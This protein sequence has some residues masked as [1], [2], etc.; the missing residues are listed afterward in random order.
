[1]SPRRP[2]DRPSVTTAALGSLASAGSGAGFARTAGAGG[3]GAIQD[4][5][6]IVEIEPDPDSGPPSIPSAA[7]ATGTGPVPAEPILLGHVIARRYEV[8]NVLGEGGMGIV[9]RCRDQATGDLVAV[10]RV[11]L[12][13]GKL[14]AEYIG[15]FYKESRALAALD[16]PGIVHARDFGQL[17]DGSPFLAMDLVTG[18]SLHDLSQ[19]RLSFPIIWSI[20]DGVLSALA[21]AHARGVVHGDLKPSNV[22][23]EQR[24]DQAPVVHILDFG[25]AWLRQ[26]P[27]DERLDG[28]KSMA[29]APHAGAGTP[30]YMAP[31]QIQHETHHVQGATDLYALGCILYK[32]I[33]GRSPFSG[34]PKELLKLH[35]YH[36]PPTPD[37]VVGAPPGVDKFVMRLL[38]KRPW[39]RFEFASEGRRSWLRFVPDSID[40][41]LL[42]FPTVA[43]PE[44]DR[45]TPTRQ[46]GPRASGAASIDVVPDRAPGLL[47]IRP[48][49]LV[50]RQEIRARLRSVAG[51]MIAG[52]GPP[53]R[54]VIL[55]GPA[56]VGKTR[57]AEWLCE[58]A[59]E[60]GRM[61]P[62]AARYRPVRTALDGMLGAITQYFN[63]ERADRDTIERSLLDRWKIDKNDRKGRS[64]VAGAA[65]WLRPMAPGDE[66]VG[67]SGMRFTLDTLELRRLVIQYT[68]RRVADGRPL[69]FFFDDLHH[70]AQTTFDGLLKIHREEL[71]Q[72]ILMLATVRSEDV[73]LGTPAA[74]RLRQL[75]EAMD[76][77]VIEVNPMDREETC[78]LVRASLPL[79]EEATAE[80]ARR[81]RGFPLFAL[82]QLHSWVHAGNLEF[83]GGTYRVPGDVLAMRPKT[84]ADLWDSRVAAVPRHLRIAAYAVATL[85]TDIRRDVMVALLN[86]LK[87]PAEEAIAQLQKAEILLPRGPGRYGWP[88]ALL[89]EHLFGRLSEREDSPRMFKASAKALRLH[90]LANTRRIVRQRVINLLYAKESDAAAETFFDFLGSSWNGA[91]EP[92]PTL[93]DLELFQGRLAGRSLALENRW[94]AEVLRHV[95]RTEEAT[96]C[97]QMARERF[98]RLGDQENLAHCLRLLGHLA[99]E[100][101]DTAEGLR[102]VGY[103][104]G[105]FDRL[106]SVLGLAQ[107]EAVSAWIEYLLGNHDKARE[108]A[109]QG[110][111]HFASLDQPLGRG[112][113]LLVLSWVDHHEGATERSRRLTTEA[114]GEFERA[115]YRLGLAQ[116]DASL[117]HIEHRLM[118]YFSAEQRAKEA[119]GL[120]EGLRTPRGQAECERLLAMVGIDTDELGVAEIRADRALDIYSKMIDPWGVVEAKL[121]KCQIALARG[122]LDN[123]RSMLGE[124]QR[125]GAREPEPK[126]HALL[127]EAWLALESGDVQGASAALEAAAD[128]F[129]DRTRV[130]DHTP[131]LLGRLSRLPWPEK[132]QARID[133][134]R[135]LVNDKGRR[136]QT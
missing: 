96:Q 72:P 125:L 40:P 33:T 71:D 4:V 101:G 36:Q 110:E 73:E 103:A 113:C 62:L 54:L 94:R 24:A 88:H 118:N 124:I 38:A 127:T 78:A 7:T 32:L 104:H 30:G 112:Q 49:P 60:D 79:D 67:P 39:D 57:V 15:W 29:F 74:E 23:V 9:Y 37:V 1:M 135:A 51:Q 106:G 14:A 55:L 34:D 129:S 10:K 58:A 111:E 5:D 95:G 132:E 43:P 19:S 21:H 27:H 92:A 76:G 121:L 116:T 69:L 18:I 97:A 109:R 26:D 28:E 42:K 35:A 98:E 85:G 128:V 93:A 80:A 99:S 68:I 63:F 3:A 6:S 105:V 102:L 52:T 61:V 17:S 48:S 65:E 16:H 64:W 41:E 13:E 56:G 70:A 12:P 100:Q 86:D 108:I 22:I 45:K 115:G 123:A 136:E 87:L 89:Q 44:E 46:T 75:R 50:G 2:E 59:H 130:G 25:L 117:A 82:Q 20:V 66:R 31:E 90:P 53:H 119:S 133:A 134:W 11:I 122:R 131:H 8:I 84:T 47:S 91:R 126:Q 120:F 114:R 81:S 107:C 77:E 83:V